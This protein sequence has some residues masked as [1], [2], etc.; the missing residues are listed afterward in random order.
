MINFF[1]LLSDKGWSYPTLFLYLFIVISSTFFAWISQTNIK[2]SNKVK[3]RII[4]L[5]Q[6]KVKNYFG[7]ILSRITSI[8]NES[9]L[10]FY[11]ARNKKDKPSI[12]KSS[13]NINFFYLSISFFILWFFSAYRMAGTDYQ[14]Y[15]IIFKNIRN[16][17]FIKYHNIEPGFVLLSKFIRLLTKSEITFIAIISF[18]TLYLVYSSIVYFSNKIHVGVAVFAYTTIFYLQSYSLIRIYLASAIILFA[19]RYLFE[20]RYIHFVLFILLA[21]GIHTSSIVIFLPFLLLILLKNKKGLI[22]T[23]LTLLVVLALSFTKYL[24][25]FNMSAR[26]TQYLTNAKYQGIGFGEFVIHVPLI[27]LY[28]YTRK[29]NLNLRIMNIFFIFIFSSLAVGML[30]YGVPV[31]GR[32]SI[33]FTYPFILFLSYVVKQIE[34]KDKRYFPILSLILIYLSG[35]LFIYMGDY[36]FLDGL[37][38]YSNVFNWKF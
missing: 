26:Y 6:S 19:S 24:I 22:V 34:S 31:V 3:Y 1:H 29:Y 7:N 35:R 5:F 28:F 13:K 25:Y 8:I 4:I 32:L 12:D 33:H 38:P 27:L 9:F 20:K 21:M 16:N 36:L 18:I 30:G 14:T 10:L 11:K 17:A 15:R 37:M 2:F 23:L